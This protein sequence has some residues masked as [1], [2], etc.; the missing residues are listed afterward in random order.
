MR[1]AAIIPAHDAVVTLGKCLEAIE[2][3]DRRPDRLIVVDD[4]STDG[5]GDVA[6]VH[7]AELLS[8]GCGPV[9]DQNR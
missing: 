8:I 1:V 5:T 3:S 7:G 2:G 9:S 4:A 6:L